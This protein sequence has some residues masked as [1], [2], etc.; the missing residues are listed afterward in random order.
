MTGM[1][2]DD[3]AR[4]IARG[5]KLLS[6]AL[7]GRAGRVSMLI[8]EQFLYAV[9]N[10]A[11]TA[12]LAQHLHVDEFAVYAAGYAVTMLLVTLHQAALCDSLFV[13]PQLVKRRE[14]RRLW[15]L[16]SI[17]LFVAMLLFA[18]GAIALGGSIGLMTGVGLGIFAPASLNQYMRRYNQ[19]R[20]RYLPPLVAAL[21]YTISVY[22]FTWLLVSTDAPA[23]H[24]MLFP[25]FVGFLTAGIINWLAARRGE[26]VVGEIHLDRTFWRSVSRFSVILFINSFIAWL[27]TN[28][29][30]WLFF[31]SNNTLEAS[32]FRIIQTNLVPYFLIMGALSGPVS[33]SFQ[34]NGIDRKAVAGLAVLLCLPL[35]GAAFLLVI[36]SPLIALIFGAQYPGLGPL[37][38]FASLCV[39]PAFACSLFGMWL[40]AQH[41]TSIVIIGSLINL[42]VLLTIGMPI[43][44][45]I[46]L[47]TVFLTIAGGSLLA[48]AGLTIPYLL[49][50][51]RRN[52][53]NNV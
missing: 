18:G 15:V 9:S 14:P 28:V 10:F 5:T 40:R 8:S 4:Y 31:L 51:R 50:R 17:V 12:I 47:Y 39:I 19:A 52:A 3:V 33:Q 13:F 41:M 44:S 43:A 21:L 49:V 48:L 23:L 45:Q 11:V 24:K 38:A 35:V 7:R 30:Q 16:I 36:G 37:A 25:Q 34:R 2:P 26:A 20:K 29:Y 1:H 27:P 42:I 22:A 46:G 53:M 32:V 6:R